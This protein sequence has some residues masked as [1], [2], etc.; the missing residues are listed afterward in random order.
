MVGIKGSAFPGQYIFKIGFL[1]FRKQVRNLTVSETSEK[2]IKLL[3]EEAFR[4]DYCSRHGMLEKSTACSIILNIAML[5]DA[6]SDFSSLV[7]FRALTIVSEF[8]VIA[9]KYHKDILS[10]ETLQDILLHDFM[11]NCIVYLDF[12]KSYKQVATKD[13][14]EL[15]YRKQAI[16]GLISVC[17]ILLNF[18]KDSEFRASVYGYLIQMF[19]N[20]RGWYDLEAMFA[21][22]HGTKHVSYML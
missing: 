6:Y 21:N 15:N 20:N 13:E 16:S 9:H 10:E 12:P 3:D 7:I 19:E 11:S 1:K 14:M 5:I 22:D 2:P 18:N 17:I 4:L 8:L